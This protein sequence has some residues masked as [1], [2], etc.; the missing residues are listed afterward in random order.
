MS[1]AWGH[2]VGVVTVLVM[3]AFIGIWVWAWL[4]YHKRA[5]DALAAMPMQDGDDGAA[6]AGDES[7]R[8]VPAHDG[9][10]R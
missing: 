2:V 10:R 8:A 7:R 4:P 6:E 1:P 3:A 5:F 9:G